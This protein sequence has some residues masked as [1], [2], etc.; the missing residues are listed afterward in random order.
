MSA[1]I[2]ARVIFRTLGFLRERLIITIRSQV[3]NEGAGN[4]RKS[5]KS[6]FCS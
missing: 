6:L 2:L 1:D 4:N 5:L 3:D